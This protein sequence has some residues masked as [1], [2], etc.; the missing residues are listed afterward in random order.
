MSKSISIALSVAVCLFVGYLSNLLQAESL[1]TWYPTLNK[2]PLTPP[3]WVFAV[4]WSILYVLIGI[5]AGLLLAGNNIT[6]RLLLALFVV[7]LFFNLLWSFCFFTM[8]SVTLGVA[9]LFMLVVM[10]LAYFF[11]AFLVERKVAYF[12]LPYLLWLFFACYLTI[13]MAMFN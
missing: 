9:V 6:K 10:A 12:F 7:Q 3:G 11:G 5:S 2:A 8:Q 1:A 4:V 13:Y